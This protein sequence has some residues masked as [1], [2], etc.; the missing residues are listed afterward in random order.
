MANCD[1]TALS[2]NPGEE[3]LLAAGCLG[4]ALVGVEGL[5]ANCEPTALSKNPPEEEGLEEPFDVPATALLIVDYESKALPQMQGRSCIH[6]IICKFAN[7]SS[8][9]AATYLTFARQTAHAMPWTCIAT[10]TC[11]ATAKKVHCNAIACDGSTVRHKN[12][13]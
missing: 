8:T 10:Q 4:A 11:I 1:P 9:T 6:H 5:E 12:R 2:K 7:H 3:G 13:Q